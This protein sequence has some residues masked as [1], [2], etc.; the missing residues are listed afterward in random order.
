MIARDNFPH[1]AQRPLDGRDLLKDVSTVPPPFY[2]ALQTSHLTFCSAKPLKDVGFLFFVQSHVRVFDFCVLQGEI[3]GPNDSDL[4][5]ICWLVSCLTYRRIDLTAVERRAIIA[6][7]R[8]SNGDLVHL[9]AE[10]VQR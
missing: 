9:H 5:V 4:H 8:R 10:I 7:I 1:R 2:H 6:Y 3:A